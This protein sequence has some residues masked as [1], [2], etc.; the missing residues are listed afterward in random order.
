MTQVFL[1]HGMGRT[2]RSL[3]L[4]AWRLERT[5]LRTSC[6]AYQVRE[7]SLEQIAARFA[8]HVREHA[9]GRYAIIGHSL[10]NVIA[11]LAS[12]RLPEGFAHFVML[13][14]PNRPSRL[15]RL[16]G[17]HDLTRSVFSAF[18]RDA[19]K[20]LASP[21]FYERLPVPS[22]PTLI[23]AGT[24]GP[25]TKWLPFAGAISDGIVALEETFLPGA[26]HHEIAAI[27]TFIMNEAS[28]AKAI[29]KFVAR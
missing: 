13:A 28:V 29:V 23:F 3:G 9:I 15:A 1:V 18:T 10:G 14:P 27:H 2:P 5:G 7:Q 19:G 12:P 22:V 8:A 20:C 17:E 16:L 21:A 25:R 26:E 11:R 6:F 24:S 4:L